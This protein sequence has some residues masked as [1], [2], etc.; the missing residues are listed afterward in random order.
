MNKQNT[1]VYVYLCD[2][3]SNFKNEKEKKKERE[4]ERVCIIKIS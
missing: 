3:T 2:N 4:R 1:Q